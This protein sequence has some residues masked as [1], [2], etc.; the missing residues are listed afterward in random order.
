VTWA[1]VARGAGTITYDDWPGLQRGSALT[2]AGPGRLRSAGEVA[3]VIAR[4]SALFGGLRPHASRVAILEEPLRRASQAPAAFPA[5]RSE[6]LLDVYRVFSDQNVQVDFIHPDEAV[7]GLTGRYDL[8]YAAGSAAQSR[9]AVDGLKA[10][11]RQ[12]GMLVSGMSAAPGRSGRLTQGLDELFAGGRPLPIGRPRSSTAISPASPGVRGGAVSVA[13]YGN[14][15]AFLVKYPPAANR[16]GAA[17]RRA[18]A[19]LLRAVLSEARVHPEIGIDGAGGLVD[20]RFLESADAM[21]LIA[22]NYGSAPREVTFRF[23]PDV[24]E[25]IW[26]NMETG[27]AVN[28][29]QTVE[30]ATYKRTFAGRDVMVLVRGKRLR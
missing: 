7:A 25:A 4:N 17:G 5:E 28:F 6:H 1:A 19:D 27:A 10:F 15:R 18:A 22:I 23:A 3:G 29:L 12:G 20:A 13:D 16:T 11:V 9:P 14:G 8:V 21:L 2:E 30:G 26:Q 24:P